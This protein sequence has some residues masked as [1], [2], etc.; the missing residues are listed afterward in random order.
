MSQSKTKSNNSIWAI[1]RDFFLIIIMIGMFFFYDLKREEPRV[2]ESIVV[3]NA[4]KMIKDRVKGGESPAEATVYMETLIDVYVA[5][6]FI[7]L[8]ANATLGEPGEV[9]VQMPSKEV[10]F[11]KAKSLGIDVDKEKYDEVQSR[12]DK[13]TKDF[14]DSL[15]LPER[16]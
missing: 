8:S 14:I 1:Y 10:L 16:H 15:K 6:G 11:D 13:M 3:L 5:E 9:R 12:I 4:E 7:V 2:S